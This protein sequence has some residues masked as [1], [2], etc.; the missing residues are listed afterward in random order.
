M[1]RRRHEA[2]C[3]LAHAARAA[4]EGSR[5]DA[6]AWRD[7]ANELKKAPAALGVG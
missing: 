3:P 6:E 5:S 7:E 1:A 4:D 2:G